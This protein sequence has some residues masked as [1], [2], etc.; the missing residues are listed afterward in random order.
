VKRRGK[1][2]EV[3]RERPFLTLRTIHRL[4]LFQPFECTLRVVLEQPEMSKGAKGVRAAFLVRETLLIQVGGAVRVPLEDFDVTE[5]LQRP[6]DRVPVADLPSDLEHLLG[7]RTQ[8]LMSLREVDEVRGSFEGRPSLRGRFWIQVEGA[9]KPLAP[10]GKVRAHQPEPPYIR[11]LKKRRR[12]M[13]SKRLSRPGLPWVIGAVALV[14]VA[15]AGIAYATNP[16]AGRPGPPAT[17]AERL[18]PIEATAPNGGFLP[19][20]LPARLE[21]APKLPGAC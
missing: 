20:S 3:V 11:R 15:A 2:D 14:A 1:E 9:T 16:P 7:E 13:M 12:L 5:Q 21:L 19:K 10:F 6:R 8:S 17:Y 4:C 18:P